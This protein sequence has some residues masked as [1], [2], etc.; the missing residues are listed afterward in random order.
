VSLDT[1]KTTFGAICGGDL[2]AWME[3]CKLDHILPSPY[4]SPSSS[5]DS[6][7]YF[8]VSFFFFFFFFLKKF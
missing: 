4:P 2:D 6:K 3:A 8:P 5:V 1:I 7:L